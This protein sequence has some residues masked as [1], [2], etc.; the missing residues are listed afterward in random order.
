MDFTGETRL[1]ERDERYGGTV[2]FD[3]ST[4]RW[5]RAVIFVRSALLHLV[6]R[7]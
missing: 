4:Y 7:R 5:Q 1:D 3:F 6:E 2:S